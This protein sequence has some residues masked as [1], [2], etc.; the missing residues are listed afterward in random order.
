M[1]E[2]LIQQK[3]KL[4]NNFKIRENITLCFNDADDYNF[5]F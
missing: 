2:N 5:G 1:L 4:Q 3:T